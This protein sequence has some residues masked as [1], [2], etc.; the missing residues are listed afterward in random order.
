MRKYALQLSLL[1][2][3]SSLFLAACTVTVPG[4]STVVPLGTPV[5]LGQ[6]SITM[7]LLSQ[8][9]QLNAGEQVT[10]QAALSDPSGITRVELVVD[11]RIVATQNLQ[12]PLTAVT[13]TLNWTTTGGAHA[14]SVRAINTA[15]IAGEAATIQVAVLPLSS[16]VAAPTLAPTATFTPVPTRAATATPVPRATAAP[17][18][19]PVPPTPTQVPPTSCSDNAVL[20]ADVTVPDNTVVRPGQTFVKTW[21]IQNTGSCAWGEGYTFLA[22]SGEAMTANTQIAVPAVAP[23]A[24]VDLSVPM[25]AP[26]QT[27]IHQGFWQLRNRNGTLF[28]TAVLVRIRVEGPAVPTATLT[29]TPTPTASPSGCSGAPSITSFTASPTTINAGQ[30]ATL[31]WGLVANADR[32]EIN[33]GIGGIAT[34][35]SISVSPT[36]TTTYTLT[37]FCGTTTRT[38]ELIINVR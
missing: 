16:P 5:S 31:S 19:T 20:I 14:V 1:L 12:T 17:T 13:T 26:M 28:G 30:S 6:P 37:A 10:I 32:A 33:N 2:L 34:P 23:G 11:N 38:A 3:A 36:T 7:S 27:G 21:R 8:S 4:N 22:V 25:T 24:T 9:T 29:T 18:N 35:G 15:G